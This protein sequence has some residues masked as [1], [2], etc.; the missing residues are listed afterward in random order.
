MQGSAGAP[1]AE[2]ATA[3]MTVSPSGVTRILQ[4]VGWCG[5]ETL[6]QL[7]SLGVRMQ[8]QSGPV[9]QW[10]THLTMEDLGGS[11][12]WSSNYADIAFLPSAGH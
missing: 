6:I 2:R 10:I 11:H 7:L 12:S 8:P 9:A 3:Q 1:T 5:A 4:G